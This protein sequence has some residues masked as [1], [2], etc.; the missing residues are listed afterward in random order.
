[1]DSIPILCGLLD[2]LPRPAPFD[3]R[4]AKRESDELLEFFID[5]Y[6]KASK[7]KLSEL[8]RDAPN[9]ERLRQIEQMDLAIEHAERCVAAVAEPVAKIG[10]SDL[11]SD[12]R[13]P[14]SRRRR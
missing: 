13:Q 6:K 8:M 14:A 9:I 12:S 7:D 10:G 1:M 4:L 5:C 11:K 2:T 3:R